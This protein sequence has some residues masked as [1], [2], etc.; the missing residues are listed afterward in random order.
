MK[1]F[2]VFF[3]ITSIVTASLFAPGFE[4]NSAHSR[5]EPE[6]EASSSV[7]VEHSE[8]VDADE[9]LEVAETLNELSDD[10]SQPVIT[11][12]EPRI[13]EEPL[14]LL[15]VN[16][17]A[18]AVFPVPEGCHPHLAEAVLNCEAGQIVVSSSVID[19]L[20]NFLEVDV[21]ADRESILLT[22]QVEQASVFPLV[23][24]IYLADSD[25]Q[26]LA[27]LAEDSLAWMISEESEQTESAISGAGIALEPVLAFNLPSSFKDTTVFTSKKRPRK[28]TIPKDY[29]YCP[30][31]CRP[32][33]RHDYCTAP[34][35][36]TWK[37]K[38]GVADF[39][40]PCARHD[41]MI[42]KIAKE[43]IRLDSKKRSGGRATC[44]SETTCNKT[45]DMPSTGVHTDSVKF[46]V[47]Q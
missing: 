11:V 32:K 5:V 43:K 30:D 8:N 28:V 22:T 13:L 33:A 14:D 26:N 6:M 12:Y 40:G 39:R 7:V 17:E 29:R 19:G 10:P 34:A 38:H 15:S 27:T 45:A 20:G 46:L 47:S 36:N 16:G 24:S 23:F 2:A 31:T 18:S 41:M 42:A 25:S 44:N 3:P 4:E 21:S 9:S 37:T 1:A 35:V